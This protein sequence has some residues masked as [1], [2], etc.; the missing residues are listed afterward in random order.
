MPKA[1]YNLIGQYIEEIKK[2]YGSHVR[3]IILYGSYARGDQNEESDMP[4]AIS[5]PTQI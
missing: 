2:I 5:D 1:M 4:E 3:Q